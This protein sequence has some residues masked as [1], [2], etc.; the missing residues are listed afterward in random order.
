MVF[1]IVRVS[2][3]PLREAPP[4]GEV[5]GT[6]FFIDAHAALAASQVLSR[7]TYAPQAGYA[8]CAYWLVG[9]GSNELIAIPRQ[10]LV[11]IPAAGTTVIA[12][13][14][15]QRRMNCLPI[16]EQPPRVGEAVRSLGYGAAPVPRLRW[17][18]NAGRPQLVACDVKSLE[19]DQVGRVQSIGNW[20]APPSYAELTSNS[21][22][23]LSYGGPGAMVGGPV[24]SQA[25][26]AAVGLAILGLP[27]NAPEKSLLL[28][29]A[30]AEIAH[31]LE[32]G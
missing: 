16:V 2:Y 27:E 14:Q 6:A 1:A 3:D 7:A 4:L 10:R 8:A 18:W 31:V 24:I 13:P 22:L 19:V 5:C 26:N 29:M 25:T 20:A 11:D 30:L 15:A 9:R 12:V 32:D 21:L 23:E 28:A 17:T